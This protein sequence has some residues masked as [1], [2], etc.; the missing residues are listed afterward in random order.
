V[1]T[2]ARD[3]RV[4][5]VLAA[6]LGAVCVYAVRQV[7]ADLYGHLVYGRLFVQSG[8]P[9]DVDPFAYT[10]AGTRWVAFE[11]LAQMSIWRAYEALGPAGLILWKAALGGLAVW[12]LWRAIRIATDDP[13]VWL[14]VFLLC[15][16]PLSRYFL[17]R[18]QVVTFACFALFTA[19]LFRVLVRRRARLWLLPLL[20]I[21]WAN[22]HGGFVAGLGAIA[23]TGALVVARGVTSRPPRPLA[24]LAPLGVTLIA[25]LGATFVTPF[26]VELWRYVLTE[27]TH[28]TNRVYI[29][30]WQPTS[31]AVDPWSVVAIATLTLTVVIAAWGA[32]RGGR[33][34]HGLP[35]WIWA[36]SCAPLLVMSVTSVRHVPLAAIWTGPVVALL[37][38]AAWQARPSRAFAAAWLVITVLAALPVLAAVQ[39]VVRTPRPVVA[40]GGTLLGSTDPCK[41]VTAMREQ[42]VRGNVY[43]PLWWG[44]YLTWRL[45]PDVRVSMDGRNITA[46]SGERVLENLRFYAE[47]DAGAARI[48]LRDATDLLLVPA[49]APVLPV[50]QNA[51]EWRQVYA[52]GDAVLFVRA[53]RLD[54]APAP[55]APPRAPCEGVLR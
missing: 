21:P 52:D 23:L 7:D 12:G 18:P 13:I 48:P 37:G 9:V 27:L 43:L 5:T 36:A 15:T 26:G 35:S 10:S 49:D 11:Y 45:Y 33:R 38:A 2:S 53:G 25:C 41:V 19:V 55:L 46:F 14:P 29:Q 3:R 30:E 39:Y 8:G 24:G 44:G 17:F 1:N 54:A 40:A 6:V 42:H 34:V 47:R 50:L 4:A 20:M 51:V 32:S 22:S 31:W 16:V 28:D